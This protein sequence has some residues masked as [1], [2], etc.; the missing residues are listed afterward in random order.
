MAETWY[1]A[2]H[3]LRIPNAP[4]TVP[5]SVT[6]EVGQPVALDGT[7]PI[8]VTQLLRQGALKPY[9]ATD[10]EKAF[11][12]RMAQQRAEQAAKDAK[13]PTRKR[14]GTINGQPAQ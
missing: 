3:K 6:V 9:G 11:I 5:S 14:R 2:M 13:R 7:E 4:G 8:N 10:E 12:D 1:L